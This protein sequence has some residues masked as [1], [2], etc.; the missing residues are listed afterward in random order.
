LVNPK[1]RSP[2]GM[3]GQGCFEHPPPQRVQLFQPRQRDILASSP[4]AMR[5]QFE[6]NLSRAQQ[7]ALR[8]APRNAQC[9]RQNPLEFSSRALFEIG[10]N[11]WMPQQT[12]GSKY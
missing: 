9:I 6:I 2:F 1:T 7:D 5:F 11:L 12:L 8:L 3:G 4:F 10:D